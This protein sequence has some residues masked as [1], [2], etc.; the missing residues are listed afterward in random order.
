MRQGSAEAMA[1]P[2]ARRSALR[3]ESHINRTLTA[4]ESTSRTVSLR[5]RIGAA[6][7]STPGAEGSMLLR[8]AVAAPGRLAGLRLGGHAIFSYEPAPQVDRT[9]AGR[10]EGKRRILLARLHLAAARG[11]ARHAVVLGGQA[12]DCKRVANDIGR[13]KD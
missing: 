13:A 12:P 9:A 3:S 11:T 4:S 10:T 8:F 1:R 7:G 6:P 2:T 5:A